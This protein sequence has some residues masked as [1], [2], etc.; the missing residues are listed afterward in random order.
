MPQMDKMCGDVGLITCFHGANEFLSNFYPC[1]LFYDGMMFKTTEAAFQAAKTLDPKERTIIA[2]MATPGKAK[3]LGRHVTLR[4]DW[5]DIKD[6]VML[7]ILRLKFTKGSLLANMLE[8]TA[9]WVL[10]EGTTWH[11]QYWGVC[12]CQEHRG[13]GR[14]LLGQIL[15]RI[16]DENRG[17]TCHL[18][19]HHEVR[20]DWLAGGPFNLEYT[21]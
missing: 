7:D 3:A 6:N 2:T 5:E 13:E 20:R 11:D 19:F 14:N 18:P 1:E 9:H 10:V 21:Q 17:Q 15:M 12:K 16:R 4:P 8:E